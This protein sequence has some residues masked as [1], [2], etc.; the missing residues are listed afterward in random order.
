MNHPNIAT[1]YGFEEQTDVVSGVSRTVRALAMELVD[2]E[3]LADRIAR[4][5]DK[6]RAAGPERSTTR[7]ALPNRLRRLSKP[8][9]S[10][11]SSTAI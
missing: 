3:T 5:P 11:A 6:V 4:G 7:C 10:T 8:H 1:I 2:G 9:M